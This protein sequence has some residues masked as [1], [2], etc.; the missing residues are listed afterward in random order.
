VAYPLSVTCLLLLFTLW[1]NI[2]ISSWECLQGNTQKV[3]KV[4]VWNTCCTRLNRLQTLGRLS[5]VLKWLRCQKQNQKIVGSIQD[6]SELFPS[7]PRHLTVRTL[8]HPV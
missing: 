6:L 5:Y 8:L 4:C 1:G 2:Y 3:H 7:L